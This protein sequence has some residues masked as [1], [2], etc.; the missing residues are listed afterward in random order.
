MKKCP[1]RIGKPDDRCS[2]DCA[3]YHAQAG[4]CAFIAMVLKLEDIDLE[5][6]S[7]KDAIRKV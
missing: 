3:L 5:L 4:E 1:L 7:I 2:S 6:E